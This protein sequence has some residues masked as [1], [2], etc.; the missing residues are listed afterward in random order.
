MGTLSCTGR[1]S[2]LVAAAAALVLTTPLAAWAA[3]AEAG[4][5]EAAVAGHVVAQAAAGQAAAALHAWGDNSAGELGN[6]SLTQRHLPVAV[7]GLTGVRSVAAG[8][9]F[10]LALL[11]NGTVAAWGDDT[12][13][14]LGNGI[15][16]SNG[17]AE[18][19]C[20]VP[21]LTG[22]VA[23][24]A[25]EEHSLALLRNGTVMAWGDNNDG[26]LGDGSTVSS[27]RP[28]RVPGLTGVTAVAAGS[29]F[30]LALLS[31]GTVMA[32]GDNQFGQL[33][34][35]TLTNSD[36]PVAVT[37]LTK[38]TAVSAGGQFALALESSGSVM[39]WGDNESD[40]L[41]DGQDVSVQ[42]LSEVPVAVVKLTN[43]QAIAAGFEFA[44]VLTT[45]G[46]V[47][48]WG[49]N[50]FF[51]LGRPNG[52]P[53]G[54]SDSDVP[55][56]LTGT[57]KV[58][59]IAAGALF[60]LAVSGGKVRAWG[61]NAFGQLGDGNTSTGPSLQTV[62]GL[63]GVTSV[64]AGGVQALAFKSASGGLGAGSGKAGPF[65]SPWRV[66]RLPA[67]PGDGTGI[68]DVILDGISAVSSTEAWAV[69]ASNALVSSTPLAEHWNGQAWLTAAVPLPAGASTATLTGVDELTATNVWAVGST[70]ATGS[71]QRTL[72]EHF[73]GSD[74]SVVPSPDPETGTSAFDELTG[75]SGTSP[76]NLWAVGTYSNGTFISLLFEHW[77]GKSWKFVSGPITGDFGTAVTVVSP[78]DVW[79]VG[80]DLATAATVS[81]HWNGHA[82]TV[83]DTPFLT[84]GTAPTNFLTG[85][86]AAGPDD[87]WASGYEGNVDEQNFMLPYVLHWN[88]KSWAL[89]KVPNA[90][91]EGSDLRALAVVSATDVWATGQTQ[92]TDGA[93]LS[94]SEH[95]NG[96]SWAIA[97][98]L[99]PG[100]LQSSP[101]TTFDGVA[102]APGHVLFAVG[103]E[104][105]PTV[106]CLLAIAERTTHG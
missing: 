103:T 57:G 52:F 98:S 53:G 80:D 81:E 85:I 93:L 39:S 17:D 97:P 55:L 62:K 84:N 26:Q 5:A 60:G 48:V 71:D 77:N 68:K 92:Q 76:D 31:D 72:I 100:S 69:G 21:G 96:K 54:I 4:P 11:S 61:D 74:W 90:G 27:V 44:V 99:D 29:Q 1:R 83:V 41:G 34:N 51:E 67:E 101:D 70:P 49:D 94:L 13:G 33:G 2:H 43:A 75:I 63:S 28:V 105:T 3:S 12:F 15:A 79:A 23:V 95:Y 9:R 19:P 56:D 8:G 38:V 40:Q 7:H 22:V 42:S 59:A 78:S 106:C 89:V 47:K 20:R 37:G 88:G 82:W 46:G 45:K 36:V 64:A 32:W 65:S 86:G 18:V 102:A 66:T 24:A 14:Q 91:S 50:G 87:V 6:A 104:E 16:S 25:G 73:N 58:T 10:E 35:G 30:S